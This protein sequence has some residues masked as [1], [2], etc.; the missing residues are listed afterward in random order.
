MEEFIIRA[1]FAAL[2]IAIIAG[3][4]GC[5]VIWKRMSYFSESISHSALLGVALGLGTGLGIHAGLVVVGVIFAGL[6]VVLQQ[7]QFLSNDAILGIFSH[8]AL[9][10]GIVILALVSDENIDYFSIYGNSVVAAAVNSP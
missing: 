9:A 10:L 8:I 7:R 2:G 6:I 3:W 5:F 4:L 1:I